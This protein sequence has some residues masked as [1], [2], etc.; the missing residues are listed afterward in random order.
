MFMNEKT[1]YC[2]DANS[3]QIGL[4]ESHWG[5]FCTHQEADSNTYLKM[6]KALKLPKQF[7]EKKKIGAT[8]LSTFQIYDKAIEINTVWYWQK[9]KHID[10][11]ERIEFKSRAI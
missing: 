10:W 4:I 6:S 5:W 3:S 1:W 7:L 2:Q 11:W 8:I 9:G